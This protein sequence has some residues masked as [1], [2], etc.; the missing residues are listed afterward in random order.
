MEHT[1]QQTSTDYCF[2]GTDLLIQAKE[3]VSYKAHKN[4][5]KS[6]IAVQKRSSFTES[7]TWRNNKPLPY[8]SNKV[9]NR[10]TWHYSTHHQVLQSMVNTRHQGI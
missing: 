2:E 4:K 7:H 1:N 3:R 8:E 6:V 9:I 10:S 5:Q